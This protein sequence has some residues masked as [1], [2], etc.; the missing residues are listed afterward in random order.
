MACRTDKDQRLKSAL[1]TGQKKKKKK[2]NPVFLPQPTNQINEQ[3]HRFFNETKE[4][5][6]I[7]LIG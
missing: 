4:Y 6:Y 1:S 7:R 5:L 2:R 3:Q